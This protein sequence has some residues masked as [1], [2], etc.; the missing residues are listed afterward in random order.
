M[1]PYGVSSVS[2]M[3][4]LG[5]A[6]NTKN[7]LSSFLYDNNVMSPNDI[8]S[9]IYYSNERLSSLNSFDNKFNDQLLINMLSN[10]NWNEDLINHINFMCDTIFALGA[11]IDDTEI[12]PEELKKELDEFI[13]GINLEYKSIKKEINDFF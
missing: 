2:N 11:P 8:C 10:N 12:K 4:L 6:G 1:S 3:I 7:Q 9:Y 5:S 13:K